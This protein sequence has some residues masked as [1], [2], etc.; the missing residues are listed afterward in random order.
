VA[1]LLVGAIQAE[2]AIAF[3]GFSVFFGLLISFTVVLMEER[4]FRRYPSW[5]DL[6]RM[7][8]AVF[9]ENL[10]YRQLNALIRVRA[11]WTLWRAKGWGEMTRVGLD[12]SETANAEL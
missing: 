2:F 6:R 8:A 4:A 11:W 5:R 10:G 3:L 9:V 1:A 12:P 7:I